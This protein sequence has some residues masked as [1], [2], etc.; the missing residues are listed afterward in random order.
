MQLVQF[1]LSI[2]RK[3]KFTLLCER[4]RGYPDGLDMVNLNNE[5]GVDLDLEIWMSH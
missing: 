1:L 2:V 3:K 4:I 5:K